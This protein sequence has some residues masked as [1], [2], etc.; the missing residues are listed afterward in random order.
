MANDV[1]NILDSIID[2]TDNSYPKG[3]GPVFDK[4]TVGATYTR[5]NY[6]PQTFDAGKFKEK[7]SLYVLH[8]LVSA[9]MHDEVTDLDNMIDSSIM[10]HIQND[11]DGSCYGYL[12]AARDR[13]KSPLLAD[14]VQEVDD[15]TEDAKN[16]LE[17]TKDD[18]AVAGEINIAVL[19]KDVTDYD[20]F[21]EK[22]KK[23]VSDKVVNDVYGVVTKRNDAPVFDDLDDELDKQDADEAGKE[24]SKKEEEDVT[25]ES[26]ILRLTGA[27]VTEYA[28]NKTPITTE[29]GSDR[30]VIE[31]CLH[32][33]DMCTKNKPKVSIWQRHK[34]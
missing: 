15:A 10:K 6:T 7:L 30:A 5:T 26:V 2:D 29:E 21:R 33:L 31:Y 28:M 9:M 32:Q 1:K 16:E 34:I 27:I 23:A 25:E 18:D 4:D 22:L 19:L 8:D 20:E 14:V 24:D 13:L 11:Y 3:K 17:D 12:C